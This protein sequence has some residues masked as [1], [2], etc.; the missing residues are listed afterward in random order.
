MRGKVWIVSR[1][2]IGLIYQN[3]AE[4]L[5]QEEAEAI[6]RVPDR[7]TLQG[8]RDYA[9]LLTLLTTGLRKAELSG[10]KVSDLKIDRNRRTGAHSEN[11]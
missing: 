2:T 3:R 7:R 6:P 9:I 11:R 5:A 4:F 10:L 1:W 8:K